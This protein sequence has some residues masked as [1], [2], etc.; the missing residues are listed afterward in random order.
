MRRANPLL[1]P[2]VADIPFDPNDH[3]VPRDNTP[4]WQVIVDF[5]KGDSDE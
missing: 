5:Y 2:G 1:I 4:W 3:P